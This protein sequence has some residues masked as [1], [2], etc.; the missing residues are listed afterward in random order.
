[1]SYTPTIG[2]EVHA[3]LKTE[4]KMFCGCKNDPHSSEVNSNICPVCLAHPGTLPVPNEHAIKKVLLFGEAV[5]ATAA[6]YSEFDRKNYFYPDI[7]KAYQISQYAFPFLSGGELEGIALTRVHLEE[8]TARNQHDKGTGSLVDFNRS[9]VPLMELVTEPVIHDQATAGQFARELQLLLR[10]FGISD[11]NM[12]RGEMRVEANISVSKEEGVLGTKVEVKNLN[13]FKSVEAA[14][15]YEIA[16]QIELLESGGEVAQ[17]TR[18]WDENRS[19][20]FSQRSKETAK[21]YRYF[22]DPDIPKMDISLIGDFSK[23]RLNEIM[24]KLPSNKRTEYENLGLTRES[25]ETMISQPELDSFFAAVLLDANA[26]DNAEV[27]TLAANYLTS[28]VV[29]LLA[30]PQYSLEQLS[31]AHY[32]EL[33]TMLYEGKIGSRVAK[34]LLSTMFAATKGPL[35]LAEEQG[36]LQVSDTSSLQGFIDEVIAENPTVVADYKAGKE[37]ALKFLVGQGMK[38]SK[39]A[40]NPAV[41]NEMLQR[42]L[43]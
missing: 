3:E 15:A 40:A 39:G 31:V 37:V 16:R 11:A 13:S 41:L 4:S 1:M 29:P 18:G 6:T 38:K 42:A 36:L 7:P 32:I 19:K 8:D 33:M 27:L 2:L 25:I 34:D 24:P 43:K 12:E 22:P 28:D 26:K 17:E 23:A 10:T 9:G 5:G 30:D 20:T 35:T 21:D 14:I